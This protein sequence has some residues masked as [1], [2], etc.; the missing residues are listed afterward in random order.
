[1]TQLT[2]IRIDVAGDLATVGIDATTTDSLLAGMYDATS[3]NE[4]AVIHLDG[5]I[6]LWVDAEGLY[7]QEPNTTLTSMARIMNPFQSHLSG[8][9]LFLATNE[10]G[11]TVTLN[12]AQAF[13]V[14]DWWKRATAN[15]ATMPVRL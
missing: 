13:R 7:R 9:G 8:A 10:D 3:C 1:M 11:D 12:P 6:D 14:I 15:P 5:E 2:G 4:V